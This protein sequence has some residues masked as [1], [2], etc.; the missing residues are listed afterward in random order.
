MIK[1][2]LLGLTLA[3]ASFCTLEAKSKTPMIDFFASADWEFFCDK[4]EILNEGLCTCDDADSSMPV[5]LTAQLVEPIIAFSSSPLPMHLVGLDQEMESDALDKHG[6]TRK[7]GDKSGESQSFIQ[8]NMISFP[9]LALLTSAIPDFI[10]FEKNTEAMGTWLSDVDPLYQNDILSN[11]SSNPVTGRA[12]FNNP[13]ADLA[14]FADCIGATADS[15]I[16]TMYWCNG[17]RGNAGSTS[18][19]YNKLGDPIEYGEMVAF[20]RLHT[21][22]ETVIAL[23]TSNADFAFVGNQLRDSMCASRYFPYILKSQYYFQLAYGDAKPFGAWRTH[24]EFKSTPDDNDA[25][26]AWIWRVRN[27]CLGQTKCNSSSSK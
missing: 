17:C 18:S 7:G 12:L 24:F 8:A 6:S 9:I 4:F 15:T 19:G 20:R 21:M 5:G 22:H 2:T 26:F 27:F 25:H 1:K 10:C 16:N 3:L 23:K 13:I 11:N 14:C